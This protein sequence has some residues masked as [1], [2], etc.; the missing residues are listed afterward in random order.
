MLASEHR[1]HGYNSLRYVYRHGKSEHARLFKIK[2]IY[3]SR[4]KNSRFAVV[5]SKKIH[6]SAVGRNRIRRRF[7]EAIRQQ[8]PLI[9]DNRDVVVIV[10]SGEA[11][12]ASYADITQSLSQIFKAASLYK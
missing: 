12:S 6:K 3:N 7:Y 1:F 11:L 8:L 2:Y 9:K 5:I 10:T 4:E